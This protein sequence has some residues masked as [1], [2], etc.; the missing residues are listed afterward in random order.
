M[1]FEQKETVAE[2][3]AGRDIIRIDAGETSVD[4]RRYYE[5]ESG[6]WAP[7]K[8]GI[9]LKKEMLFE[10]VPHLLDLME[11]NEVHDIFEAHGYGDSEECSDECSDESD[12][13]IDEEDETD[14]IEE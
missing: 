1:A 13:D 12:D 5:T 10:I 6:E 7:T 3:E 2:I 11:E 9:C 4:I 8:K 14:E